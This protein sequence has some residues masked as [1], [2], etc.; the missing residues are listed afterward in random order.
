MS[1]DVEIRSL[2]EWWPHS[3]RFRAGT[4]ARAKRPRVPDG[5]SP[6]PAARALLQAA[7]RHLAGLRGE[8][9]IAAV[10]WIEQA[11]AQFPELEIEAPRR[12][13]VGALREAAQVAGDDAAVPLL[14]ACVALDPTATGAPVAALLERLVQAGCGDAIAGVIAILRRRRVLGYDEIVPTL[15][16]LFR[17][18]QNSAALGVIV[19]MLGQADADA[20][21]PANELGTA[22]RTL[23][24]PAGDADPF[25]LAKMVLTARKRVEAATRPALPSHRETSLL[26]L[27]ERVAAKL[28][29]LASTPRRAAAAPSPR[30]SQ[31]SAAG[32]FAV[33]VPQ[34]RGTAVEWLPVMQVGPAGE[35]NEAGISARTGEAGHLAYGPYAKLSAGD[36]RLRVGWSAGPP[37]RAVPPDEAVATIEAV[38]RYG[39]TYLAQRTL[40]IED[41]DQ[42]EHDLPFRVVGAPSPATTVEVRVWTSGVVPLTLRSIAIELT[43]VSPPTRSRL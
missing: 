34:A 36:Y 43:D 12:A 26:A 41:Y 7:P 10:G 3:A 30:R 39:R 29:E 11:Y 37:L 8:A 6:L 9:L 1:Q 21:H 20:D 18:Q 4:A 24:R 38:S 33:A 27:A 28:P 42:P 17:R 35:R 40:R 16:A 22:L 19:Q 32:E 14:M 15:D 31:P 2:A 25:T 23:V 13:L 5:E